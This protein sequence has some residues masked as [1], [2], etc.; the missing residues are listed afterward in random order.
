MK[1]KMFY[2]AAGALLTAVA[3]MS[4]QA[5]AASQSTAFTYQGQL[6]AGGTLPSG[7]NYQFTFTLYDAVTGGNAVGSAIQ[8]QI[9]VGNG[10]L[11]TTDLDFGQLF[12]GQQYWLE[13]KVGSTVGN[14]QPLAA[15]QPVS[16]VP[17][18]QYALNAPT[19]MVF[20]SSASQA[21]VT[22]GAFGDPETIAVLPLSGN[23]NSAYE[24]NFIG[25]ILNLTPNGS[26][27]PPPQ[28]IP[29]NGILG[30]ISA[31]AF[32]T[33]PVALI[34]A[35]VIIQA[36]LYV[37]TIGS[38]ILVPTLTCQ[39]APALTGIVST[40]TSASCQVTGA[41]IP[42]SAGSTAMI[43]VSANVNGIPLAAQIPIS[44]SVGVGP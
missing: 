3:L 26:M 23:V 25:G 18:A 2:L 8:Q 22:T 33:A 12:N 17:V 38:S 36:Q 21:I 43:V 14:E 37:G 42:V 16:A 34:G 15:R 39:L 19:R 20:L 41:A 29:V 11:F 7:Q 24:T 1:L 10:G 32:V 4:S 6:N 44:I 28:V 40:G 5:T 27:P 31:Q 35:S 9:L 13:I 30:S